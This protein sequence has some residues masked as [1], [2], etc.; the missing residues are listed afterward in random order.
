MTID[1]LMDGALLQEMMDQKYV[2][3]QEHPSLP[4]LRIFNY[5]EHAQ[6]DRVW[7]Q[8][9]RQCRGHARMAVK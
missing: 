5:T 7:N 4:H 9:T 1:E 8:V 3:V 2:R 6:F